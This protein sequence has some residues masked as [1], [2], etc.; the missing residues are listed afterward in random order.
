MAQLNI[1]V[2]GA[3]RATFNAHS[4]REL[5]V[6]VMDK[7]HEKAHDDTIKAKFIEALEDNPK[8]QQIII[9]WWLDNQ[10]RVLRQERMR[11]MPARSKASVA[12]APL[13]PVERERH[14][15]EVTRQM[16][17]KIKANIAKIALRDMVLPN[18]KKLKDCTFGELRQLNPVLG[19]FLARVAAKGKKDEIV[20]RVLSEVDLQNLYSA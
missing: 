5:L 1:G 15:T 3:K 13:T 12:T 9:E 17:D 19:D 2:S 18:G 8:C 11:A 10:L 6:R 20:G 14:K 16:V 4:P 7:C